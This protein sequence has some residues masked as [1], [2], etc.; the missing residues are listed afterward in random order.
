MITTAQEYNANLHLVY[1]TNP[2]IFAK[3]PSAEDIYN[4]DI[5]TR[6]IESPQFLS[7]EHDHASE[8]IY[9]I[10]DRYAEYMDL[11]DTCCIIYYI[12]A[13]GKCR[14]YTVP[15]YDIYSYGHDKKILI[16]WVLD[17]T[18]AIKQGTVEFAIQFFKIEK[19]FNIETGKYDPVIAYSLN[20]LPA[21]STVLK[22]IN[23][24]EV[25]LEDEEK[26]A[27]W[28]LE[29]SGEIN[30]IKNREQIKWTRLPD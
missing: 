29:L 10:V 4:I 25:T 2:P 21:K 24:P 7:V 9:F 16:P 20:T 28:Y 1:N 6:T 22:G 3:L 27:D 14:I 19:K 30:E 26:F 23:L 17:K 5:N 13:D 15:F 18:V 12:S 8:T 11:A